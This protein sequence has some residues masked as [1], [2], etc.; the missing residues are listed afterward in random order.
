MHSRKET[1][2][3]GEAMAEHDSKILAPKLSLDDLEG[4][5]GGAVI[6]YPRYGRTRAV[7]YSCPQCGCKDLEG[8][9]DGARYADLAEASRATR[10]QMMRCKS[11]GFETTGGSMAQTKWLER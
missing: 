10:H 3:G 4:V 11:C 7:E 9:T 5:I 6:R 1:T 8:I 2:S